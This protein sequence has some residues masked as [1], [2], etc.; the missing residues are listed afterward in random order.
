MTIA[1]FVRLLAAFVVGST[2]TGF[3]LEMIKMFLAS[4][5]AAA[6]GPFETT[7]DPAAGFAFCAPSD[8]VTL[9][10]TVALGNEIG[11]P[12]RV[13]DHP[14]T[15]PPRI[16]RVVITGWRALRLSVSFD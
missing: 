16:V 11:S 12:G 9:V 13:T 7:F 14:A 1:L 4:G 2:L 8:A 15:S 6:A 5:F 3:G 10:G